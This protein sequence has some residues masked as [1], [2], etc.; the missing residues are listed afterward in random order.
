MDSQSLYQNS[1]FRSFFFFPVTKKLDGVPP[2]LL[3]SRI[4]PL[5]LV[6]TKNEGRI[7]QFITGVELRKNKTNP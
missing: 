4:Q 1:L 5:T 2:H 6:S 3:A 7:K